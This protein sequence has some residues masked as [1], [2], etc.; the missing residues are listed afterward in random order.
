M[1]ASLRTLTTALA[2]VVVAAA[3]LAPIA[4]AGG[5]ATA[6]AAN[7]MMGGGTG[8][9]SWCAGGIWNGSGQWGGT[10]MWGT[11][12]GMQWLTDNPAAL[13]AWL[14]L[15]ADHQQAMQAWYDTYKADLTTPAAQ[16]ALHDLWLAN[17]N[18]MKSFYEQYAGG[19]DWTSPSNG[20]WGGWQMGSMMGGGTWDPHHMWG[21]GYGASWMT[22]HPAGMGQWL[23]M[24]GRQMSAM[25]AWWQ[26]SSSAPGGPAAQAALKTLGAR[27]RTQVKHFYRRHH[28]STSPAM[29]RAASGGWMGLGGMWGG[30]GW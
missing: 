25:N 4:S 29:M 26:Q 27:Q 20:M 24:R 7:G 22:S 17:W 13:E 12:S 1:K 16:Q 5:S 30:F 2:V 6:T 28:L 9:G 18:D 19:A 23:T 21:T 14:Q 11:G 3:L 10:G 15:R 8:T